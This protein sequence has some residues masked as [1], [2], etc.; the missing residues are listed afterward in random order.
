VEG[1]GRSQ[2]YGNVLDMRKHWMPIFGSSVDPGT[3]NAGRSASHEHP[4]YP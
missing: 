2:F 1:S 4:Y 3:W